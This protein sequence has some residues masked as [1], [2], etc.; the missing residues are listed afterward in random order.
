ME[1]KSDTKF[2]FRVSPAYFSEGS[3][4][5][6]FTDPINLSNFL[7]YSQYPCEVEIRKLG[8]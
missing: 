1:L 3:E 5:L 2:Y 4:P 8:D 6:I 7:N